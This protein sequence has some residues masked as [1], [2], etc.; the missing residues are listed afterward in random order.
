MVPGN[1]RFSGV[2]NSLAVSPAGCPEYEQLAGELRQIAA[3]GPLVYCPNPGNWGGAL[4]IAGTLA[5]FRHFGI[6]VREIRA[7]NPWRLLQAKVCGHALVFGGGGAWGGGPFGGGRNLVLRARPWFRKV[8]VLPSTYGDRVELPGCSLWARDRSGSLAAAPGARFCHDM[9]FFRG[10]IA[11]IDPVADR[12]DFFRG[13]ALSA[14]G[15]NHPQSGPPDL[16]ARGTHLSSLKPF[17]DEI[18]RYREIHTDRVHV[19]IAAAL[20]GRGCVVYRTKNSL[21]E[22]LFAASLQP[23]FPNATLR[24]PR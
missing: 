17:L 12:G 24:P 1:I 6:P 20:L 8:V 23:Y 7:L 18:G 2:M 4:T 16:S 11:G 14:S 21:L 9:G 10:P 22:D 5:F 13:D 3:E 15:G 19:A